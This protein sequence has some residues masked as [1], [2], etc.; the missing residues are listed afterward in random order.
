MSAWN[1]LNATVN[2]KLIHNQ[3]LA[4]SCYPGPRYNPTSCQYISNGWANSSIISLD[5]LGYSYP[6]FDTC[7]PV[8]TSVAQYPTC[9]LGNCPVYTID[10][11][12]A[13]D[14]ATGIKFAKEN[15]VRLVIKNT[16]H[17]IVG[18]S[19]GYD[20]LMIWIKHIQHGVNFHERYISPSGC[21]SN[22]TGAAFTVS[23]GYAWGDLY[24]EA[25][26][27]D[28]MAV[29]GNDPTVG[30]IG[31]YI[32]GAGHGPA[33][34]HFGLATDQV[35]EMTVV[36]AS[37]KIVIA[38]ACQNPDLFTAL[39]GGGGGTYGV[40]VSVTIKAFPTHPVLTHNLGV[41]PLNAALP[42]LLNVTSNIVPKYPVLSDAGFSGY[43]TVGPTALLGISTDAPGI[44]GHIF[45]KMLPRDNVSATASIQH[46]KNTVN[47]HLIEDLLPY[48]GTAFLITSEW[49]V[50]SSFYEY[51]SN[52]GGQAPVGS[53]DIAITSRLFDKRALENNEQKLEAM[54]QTVFSTHNDN[55]TLSTDDTLLYLCLIGG[56]R[57]LH[58][59]PYIS[60][61]PGWRKTYLLSEILATWPKDASSD[62]IQTIKDDVTHRKMNAMRA[63]TPGMGSYL[64]EADRHDPSWKE[65]FWGQNYAWLR[66]VKEKYDPD[67]VFW[68]YPC[69]GSEGWGEVTAGRGYGPLCTKE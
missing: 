32:Q 15:N 6:L 1:T 62:V 3:P 29:G 53:T 50:Y 44:Y 17:D 43:G 30:V 38:S 37:G 59:Q 69:V 57:V 8:N 68:C 2:G 65:D 20:S 51:Y 41:I 63:L 26:A 35:L 9:D 66:S 16:G 27:R 28:H 47:K 56:G 31:G 36:L 54:M 40:V 22:W 61:N 12:N 24:N 58:P 4:E 19:Q 42:A 45:G 11:T 52:T 46:A 25:A 21:P 33:S 55:N 39:R 18:R 7:P 34:H 49:T 13:K 64:N 23:G 48:N 5:P 67:G 60:V 14:I 10:A